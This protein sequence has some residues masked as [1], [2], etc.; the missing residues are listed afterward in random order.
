MMDPCRCTGFMY[1]QGSGMKNQLEDT[2]IRG[3]TMK[4]MN[5][6]RF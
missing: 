3:E 4:T 1:N 6:K 2:E 5:G